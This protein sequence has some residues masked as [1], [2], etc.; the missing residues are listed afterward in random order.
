MFRRAHA[1][2]REKELSRDCLSLLNS[3]LDLERQHGGP[4]EQDK[5][6]KMMPRI[7]K[8]TRKLEGDTY[9]E[10]EDYVF[11]DA[12]QQAKNVSNLLAMAKNWRQAGTN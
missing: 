3:W 5:V 4:D 7:V 1:V 6:R 11:P 12:E 10:Y 8:K 2:L 9:E